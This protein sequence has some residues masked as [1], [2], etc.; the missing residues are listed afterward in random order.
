MEH[1][2][3]MVLPTGEVQ[4]SVRS[5]SFHAEMQSCA[6][7]MLGHGTVHWNA[8]LGHGTV[9]AGTYEMDRGGERVQQLKLEN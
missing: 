3:F 5:G 6:V 4:L 2:A 9:Q 7:R 8:E 1:F